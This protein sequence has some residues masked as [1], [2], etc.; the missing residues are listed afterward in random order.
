MCSNPSSRV[1][2]PKNESP[3]RKKKAAGF[4]V[5]TES[6]GGSSYIFEIRQRSFE[7]DKAT[8]MDNAA[9]LFRRV[10]AAPASFGVASLDSMLRGGVRP[11]GILILRGQTGIGKSE[12]LMQMAAN[13]LVQGAKVVWISCCCTFS[14]HRF[15]LVLEESLCRQRG[16]TLQE[17]VGCLGSPEALSATIEGFL[18]NIVVAQCDDPFAF[19]HTMSKLE[20]SHFIWTPSSIA[21]PSPSSATT[22]AVTPTLIVDGW[23]IYAFDHFERCVDRPLEMHKAFD[24]VRNRCPD[25]AIVIAITT[26]PARDANG[27]NVIQRPFIPKSLNGLGGLE[28]VIH[29]VPGMVVAGNGNSDPT[30]GQTF[31][32]CENPLMCQPGQ[33]FGCPA[34]THSDDSDVSHSNIPPHTHPVVTLLLTD[35]NHTSTTT[36]SMMMPQQNLRRETSNTIERFPAVAVLRFAIG[37][38]GVVILP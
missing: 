19:V 4:F 15:A 5:F 20:K 34:P 33:R 12:W 32:T 2:F 25:A 21:S 28:A 29:F 7:E 8:K 26:W 35:P 23:G 38:H 16:K 11:S 27:G 24:A 6:H 22:P 9:N 13:Q 10:R 18:A 14:V 36:T 37:Q 17:L 30:C 3:E 1:E 31:V